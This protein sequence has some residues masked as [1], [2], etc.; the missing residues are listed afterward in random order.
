MIDPIALNSIVDFVVRIFTNTSSII[1]SGIVGKFVA[2]IPDLSQAYSYVDSFFDFITPYFVYARDA[3]LLHPIT[4]MLIIATIIFKISGT[5][6]VYLL[7]LIV[8][9]FHMLK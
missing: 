7:K 1:T 4:F 5:S 8:R 9:W 3:T 2:M 6:V